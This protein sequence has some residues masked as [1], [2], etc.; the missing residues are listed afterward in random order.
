VYCLPLKTTIW[1]SL[2][3]KSKTGQRP[4]QA[5]FA[6]FSSKKVSVLADLQ[7]EKNVL[8]KS[9]EES[10]AKSKKLFFICFEFDVVGED[11]N[12]GKFNR[13]RGV[14]V[15]EVDEF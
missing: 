11:T 8:L 14:A 4:L 2:I 13:Q 12:N 6:Y 3:V 10:K 9:N 7:E 5:D 1:S 15:V